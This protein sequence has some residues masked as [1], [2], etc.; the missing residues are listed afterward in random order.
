MRARATRRSAASTKS[1]RSRGFDFSASAPAAPLPC[2]AQ[3]V[4][5]D[6]TRT[7]SADQPDSA[8]VVQGLDSPV[9]VHGVALIEMV[10]LVVADVA[11][12]DFQMCTRCTTYEAGAD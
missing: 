9:V 6:Q 3:S 5:G 11:Q 12:A 1:F 4:G 8:V 2:P 10:V 7:R